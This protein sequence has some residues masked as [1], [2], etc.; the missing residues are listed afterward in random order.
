MTDKPPVV[1]REPE[2]VS[3]L[4][5]LQ[6][7]EEALSVE[8]ASRTDVSLNLQ[9]ELLAMPADRLRLHLRDYEELVRT[10]TSWQAPAGILV[11]L[12]AALVASDFK[13]I[14][15][16]AATWEALF[17]LVAICSVWFLG[18]ALIHAYRARSRGNDI[19]TLVERLRKSS[20]RD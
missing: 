12:V 4:A 14:G 16:E 18:R 8:M 13:D 10:R 3:D 9:Q 19:E 7:I 15:L 6:P 1:V 5:L 11:S 17:I 2:A 20:L